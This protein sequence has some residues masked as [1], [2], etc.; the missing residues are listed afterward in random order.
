MSVLLRFF[1]GGGLFR[2]AP[3]PGSGITLVTDTWTATS[4][5]VPAAL[6]RRAG[7]T[8]WCLHQFRNIF[9]SLNPSLPCSGV[10]SRPGS[11]ARSCAAISTRTPRC[12]RRSGGGGGRG[13]LCFSQCDHTDFWTL[14]LCRSTVW[15]TCAACCRSSTLT[16][17]ISFT[18]SGS[19]F[20]STL[21]EQACGR[22]QPIV[23]RQTLD[24]IKDR[25][26]ERHLR[27]NMA[28]KSHIV[29]TTRVGV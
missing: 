26:N 7:E 19:P 13:A 22:Q 5:D 18:A 10:K 20:S 23:D 8:L 12:A 28:R 1:W 24:N 21:G 29:K 17:Q 9:T 6:E 25:R 15:M 27:L 16:F 3:P 4:K 2:S 11:T 14:V